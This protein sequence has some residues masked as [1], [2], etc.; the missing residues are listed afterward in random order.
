[1]KCMS[2]F[3]LQN[4]FKIRGIDGINRKFIQDEYYLAWEPPVSFLRATIEFLTWEPLQTQDIVMAYDN[5]TAIGTIILQ[6]KIYIIFLFLQQVA[7][8]S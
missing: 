8:V 2:T 5:I 7:L 3:C 1:M 4:P 6:S